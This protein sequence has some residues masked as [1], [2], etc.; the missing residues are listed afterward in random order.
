M[1]DNLAFRV[2]FVKSA[3]LCI[4]GIWKVP[5][6]LQKESSGFGDYEPQMEVPMGRERACG[7]L[8]WI[9]KGQ[10]PLNGVETSSKNPTSDSCFISIIEKENDSD[11]FDNDYDIGLLTV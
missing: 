3:N 5:H 1:F 4:R 2:N 7:L 9:F 11:I 6:F 8:A 10:R